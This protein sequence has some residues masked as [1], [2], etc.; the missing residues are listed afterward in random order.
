MSNDCC[1]WSKIEPR[2]GTNEQGIVQNVIL[3]KFLW[4]PH[5][6]LLVKTALWCF[7][8]MRHSSENYFHFSKL[9]F[10]KHSK[11]SVLHRFQK[12]QPSFFKLY[13]LMT[14]CQK[15]FCSQ[16][17]DFMLLASETSE[18]QQKMLEKYKE[19]R[20]KWLDMLS[21]N[22]WFLLKHPCIWGQLRDLH[23]SQLL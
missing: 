6:K 8:L 22:N 13:V 12:W 14:S 3:C 20:S 19:V 17:I 5:N 18:K 16:C 11:V 15:S 21:M 2:Q 23:W 4:D 1:W 10:Y 9:Q 7:S